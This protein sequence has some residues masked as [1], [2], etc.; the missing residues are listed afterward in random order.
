M[1]DRRNTTNRRTPYLPCGWN[2]LL[3]DLRECWLD[4]TEEDDFSMLHADDYRAKAI[5]DALDSRTLKQK[6]RAEYWRSYHQDHHEERLAYQKKYREA[7][8][9]KMAAFVTAVRKGETK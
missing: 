8:K 3:C 2:C 7:H 6:R 1:A 5:K 9:E 4:N